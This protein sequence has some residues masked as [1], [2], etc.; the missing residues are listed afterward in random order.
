MEAF[1]DYY[2]VLGVDAHAPADT[3]KAAFKKLALQYHPDIYKGEDAEER[4]R[5]LLLAYQTLSD[6]ASRR[7]YDVLRAE[8]LDIGVNGT[9]RSHSYTTTGAPV[10]KTSTTKGADGHHF[11]FPNLDGAISYA[12]EFDL[13][14]FKCCAGSQR[15]WERQLALNTIAIAAIIAGPLRQTRTPSAPRVKRAIGTNTCSCAA[16]TARPSLKARRYATR[17]SGVGSTSPMNFFHS[18]PIAAGRN[19]VPPR[20][21]A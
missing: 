7:N 14:G 1:T 19:G 5:L 17:Y 12:V 10:K 6:P 16:C 8:H 4:M 15:R 20:M 2:T 18:A 11:A 13:D 21:R 3:I 9:A